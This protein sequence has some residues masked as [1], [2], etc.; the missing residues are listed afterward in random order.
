AR[1]G[2]SQ[3]APPARVRLLD[4]RLPQVAPAPGRGRRG[5][6]RL[7]EPAPAARSRLDRAQRFRG[8][9]LGGGDRLGDGWVLDRRRL[10]AGG[11]ARGFGGR[12]RGGGDGRGGGWVLDRRRVRAG[13]GGPGAP[14]GGRRPA[15]G[16]RLLAQRRVRG[17]PGGDRPGGGAVLGRPLGQQLRRGL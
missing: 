8:R 9:Q 12:G 14:R 11:G 1:R 4:R 5:D 6:G 16:R 7:A 10:P 3:P 17:G 13:R 15:R 2:F